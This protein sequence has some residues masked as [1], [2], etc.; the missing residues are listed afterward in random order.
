MLKEI[1]NI[2]FLVTSILSV[3]S[4]LAIMFSD[5]YSIELYRLL[6]LATVLSII[7]GSIPFLVIFGSRKK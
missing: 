4:A 6:V 2:L 3:L 5:I 7:L 1:K